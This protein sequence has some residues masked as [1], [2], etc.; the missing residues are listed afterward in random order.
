MSAIFSLQQCDVAIV[1]VL[2]GFRPLAWGEPGGAQGLGLMA[3]SGSRQAITY[4]V[5]SILGV[6]WLGRLVL[7]DEHDA[8]PIIWPQIRQ[9][10]PL[11]LSISVSGGKETNKDSPS[12]GE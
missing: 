4:Q 12:N 6:V 2:L 3:A 1:W 10:Y 5:L 11:N 9:D 7:C 8:L